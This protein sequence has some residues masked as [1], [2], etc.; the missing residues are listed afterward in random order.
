MKN[1]YK[2]SFILSA[3]SLLSLMVILVL[4]YGFGLPLDGTMKFVIFSSILSLLFLHI[5]R[6]WKKRCETDEDAPSVGT[7]YHSGTKTV[8]KES[9]ME[10]VKNIFMHDYAVLKKIPIFIN[11]E[12]PGTIIVFANGTSWLIFEWFPLDDCAITEQTLTV[13]MAKAIGVDVCRDDRE[14]FIIASNDDIVIDKAI[15]FLRTA[16]IA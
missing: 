15:A 7:Q 5:M 6:D 16:R 1:I 3:I 10:C 11:S 8:I 14:R 4:K 13:D 2:L 12:D 9:E